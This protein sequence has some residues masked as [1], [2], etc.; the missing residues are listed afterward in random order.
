M[1]KIDLT[2]WFSTFSGFSEILFKGRHEKN[3][4]GE[5]K[6][7]V[8]DSLAN[9]NPLQG[10]LDEPYFIVNGA[11]LEKAN[12][13]LLAFSFLLGEPFSHEKEGE[14]VMTVRPEPSENK[15]FTPAYNNSVKFNLHSEL[16]YV[17]I[18]PD[19]IILLCIENK[20]LIGTNIA[21]VTE[22]LSMLDRNTIQLLEEPVY[23]VL[24]PPHFDAKTSHATKRSF[25]KT[26]GDGFYDLNVRFDNVISPSDLHRIALD[27]FKRVAD[28]CIS[29]I[30]TS[31]SEILVIN[32]K[33]C[34]HGRRGYISN[35][36]KNERELRR[37]YISK[38]PENFGSNF[39]SIT[40][41]LSNF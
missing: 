15:S 13:S 21:S 32:N 16:P 6:D 18:P 22:V 40:R 31:P 12:M 34:L 29:E 37:V 17:S 23:R 35:E 25:V 41:K 33:A 19:Y 36:E 20:G 4:I 30:V 5:I 3:K 1:K 14:L 11:L 7:F 27:K 24:I 2:N 28:Q 26:L 10:I 8:V 39:N 9:Q 38:N